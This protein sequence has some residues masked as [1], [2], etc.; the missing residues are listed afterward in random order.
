MLT[1]IETRVMRCLQKPSPSAKYH[2]KAHFA[3][4]F[5]VGGRNLVAGATPPDKLVLVTLLAVA[6]EALTSISTEP[7]SLQGEY[8]NIE[9]RLCRLPLVSRV[10]R[11]SW[12]V[13]K[14]S[15]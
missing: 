9:P 4:V 13:I 5:R 2:E 3:K 15:P 11:V 8:I 12:V 1:C 14:N 10:A 6:V 7:Q